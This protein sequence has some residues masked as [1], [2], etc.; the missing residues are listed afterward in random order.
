MTEGSDDAHEEEDYE[1]GGSRGGDDGVEVINQFVGGP[2][3]AEAVNAALTAFKKTL[4]EQVLGAELTYQLGYGPRGSNPNS[5][6][7]NIGG[8]H[9]AAPA[10]SRS[11]SLAAQP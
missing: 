10:A 7:R 6:V 9:E 4:I 11:A 2:M 1:S 5:C 8:S 3:S